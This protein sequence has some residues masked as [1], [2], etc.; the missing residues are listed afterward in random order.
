MRVHPRPEPERIIIAMFIMADE[1]KRIIA[2][3]FYRTA[4][5]MSRR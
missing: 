3:E 1:K 5:G 4:G 2:K